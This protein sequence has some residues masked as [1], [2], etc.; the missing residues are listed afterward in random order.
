[1]RLETKALAVLLAVMMVATPCM[2]DIIPNEPDARAQDGKSAKV[3]ETKLSQ[4]GVTPTESA[5]IMSKLSNEELQFLASNDNA[6]TVVGQEDIVVMFWYE[7]IFAA[8]AIGL[9]YWAWTEWGEDA[10][11]KD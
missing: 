11:F 4:I 10:F 9:G 2:A 5:V 1:M 3:V 6:N 7:W 8:V